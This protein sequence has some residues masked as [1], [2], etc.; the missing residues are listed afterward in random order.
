M[1]SR[2]RRSVG[3]ALAAAF[4][5]LPVTAQEAPAGEPP[6]AAVEE[7]TP[8]DWAAPPPAADADLLVLVAI[9]RIPWGRQQDFVDWIVAREAEDATRELPIVEW[10]GHSIGM[11]WDYVAVVPVGPTERTLPPTEL[12]ARNHLVPGDALHLRYE[13]YVAFSRDIFAMGEATVPEIIRQAET[14]G[15]G[16]GKPPPV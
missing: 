12:A 7:P 1:P 10:Y 16:P 5:V 13:F 11:W 6:P 3:L 14:R 15:W 4:A 9:Y 2:I 8:P